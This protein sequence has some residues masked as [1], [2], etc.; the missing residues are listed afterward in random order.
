MF[1]IM[2]K[3]NYE[4]VSEAAFE[5]FRPVMDKENCVLGLATGS[6]PLGL[7]KKMIED[8]QKNGTSYAKAISF[9]LDEYVGLPRNHKE[10]YYTFMHENLFNHIDIKEENTHVPNGETGNPEQEC[11]DYE[12]AL[13]KVS[14]DVQI[15]GIGSD[16]HIAFNE[17][18]ASFES[19]THVMELTEQTRQ[20][21]ARFF[22]GDINQV[23]TLAITQGL[24]SIMRAKKIIL[25]ATGANKAQAVKNM[26][27]GEKSVDCPASIL[28][29]HADVTVIL[30]EMAAS[31]LSK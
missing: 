6:S 23:P 31:S 29:D 24:A 28:Q 3:K 22:A 20:D 18:G 2:V 27:E 30:D 10:S 11:K 1:K 16:G 7:Y 15:L 9:N 14:V 13:K 5:A 21:N 4:E 26:L 12:T 25:I 17:P 19:E 8:H